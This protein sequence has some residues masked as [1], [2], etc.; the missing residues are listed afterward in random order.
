M[1]RKFDGGEVKMVVVVHVDDIL[2]HVPVTVERF[3]A[4]LGRKFKV[5]PM[6]EKFGVKMAS[7]TPA[8][9]GVAALS[10]SG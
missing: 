7:R 1:S 9:S 10:Q 5:E 3:P 2:A 4:E 6:V 8:S